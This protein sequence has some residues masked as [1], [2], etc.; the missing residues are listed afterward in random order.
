MKNVSLDEDNEG[1]L[2]LS[3]APLAEPFSL[4]LLGDCDKN[5]NWIGRRSIPSGFLVK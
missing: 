3:S 5:S 2:E 1:T 4:R